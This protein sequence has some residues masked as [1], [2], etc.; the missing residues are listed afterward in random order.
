[1]IAVGG[2]RTT[3]AIR[4]D[5]LRT[6]GRSPGQQ[7]R[8]MGH[9]TDAAHEAPLISSWL[10][11]HLSEETRTI[12]NIR[13][14]FG[15]VTAMAA[16]ATGLAAVG[17]TGAASASTSHAAVT[18][19][20][21]PTA[22]CTIQAF[23]GHYLSA[24]DGGGRT[25]DVIET[26]RTRASTWETFTLVLSDDRL[27]YGIMTSNG[28]YLTAVGGG[29]RTTDVI[30]SNA[31]QLLSWEKFSLVNYLGSGWYAIRTVD[32]HF[33]TAVDSGGRTTDTIHSNATVAQA[34]EEFYF[35]CHQV[36]LTG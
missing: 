14:A 6:P 28:H 18:A 32:G 24:I 5:A 26:N 36:P 19:D 27:S 10:G 9:S 29:G 17:L 16:A 13:H 11:R 3:D 7:T 35:T 34:W 1:V 22:V 8:Q 31:T 20:L 23:D 21:V 25:T 33:L 4:T 12:V 30:H 2:G 15:R